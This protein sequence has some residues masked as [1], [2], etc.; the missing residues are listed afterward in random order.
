MGG[1]SEVAIEASQLVL[2]DN[3]FASILIAIENGRLVADNIR[4]VILYLLPAGSLAGL[5]PILLSILFGM[6]Q[7]LSSF[8]MIAIPFFTDIAPSLSLIMEKP[9]TNLLKQRPRS[10]VDS[11]I[12][13]K[14]LVQAYLFLGLLVSFFSQLNFF[15]YMYVHHHI[16][17]GDLLFGFGTWQAGF[18][19]HA[20]EELDEILFTGQTVTFVSLVLTQIFGNLLCTRTHVKSFFNTLPLFK[21]FKNTWIVVSQI[22]SIFVMLVTIYVPFFNRFFN[23]R[24]VPFEFFLLPIAYSMIIF[25]LD[26]ARKLLVRRKILFFHKIGW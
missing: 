21:P 16:R 18:M 26:E 20:S 15:V 4:K 7:N 2:L 6:P 8:Q 9:E 12:D 24:H 22:A 11:L 14:F 17:P 23:T 10:K 13:W 3:N 25:Y 19:G 5:I 1:G